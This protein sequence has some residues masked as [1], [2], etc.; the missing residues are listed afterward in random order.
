MKLSETVCVRE[1]DRERGGERNVYRDF[2]IYYS[3]L[4]LFLALLK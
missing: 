1:R 3:V 2:I 4:S